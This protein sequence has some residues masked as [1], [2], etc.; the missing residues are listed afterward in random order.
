MTEWNPSATSEFVPPGFTVPTY[1]ADRYAPLADRIGGIL[2]TTGD[3]VFVQAEAIVAL[4]A[5]AASVGAPGRRVLVLVTSPYGDVFGRWL[6]AAGSDVRYLRAAGATAIHPDQLSIALEQTPA[7]VVSITHGEAATGVA[8]PLEQLAAVARAHGAL[9]V[10]DAV[11]SVGAHQLNVDAWGIDIAVIGPQK[12]LGGP[13]ALSAV[14]VSTAAWA[15]FDGPL[16]SVLSLIDLK[17]DWLDVGRGLLPGTPD[18]R[19]FWALENAVQTFLVEGTDAVIQRHAQASALARAAVSA[20]VSG[21]GIG[22]SPADDHDASHL[23]TLAPVPVGIDIDDLVARA[24]RL[25]DTVSLALGDAAGRF[26][27]LN[28]TGRRANFP[29]VAT[30]VNAYAIALHGLGVDVDLESLATVLNGSDRA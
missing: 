8:N 27:R 29:S 10:V 17:R 11:A 18:P 15:S 19:S 28:H 9:V 30:A 7:D 24:R 20:T 2:G 6:E 23:V 26:V 14:A 13:A 21:L 1:P 4:E 12:A 16:H 22:P 25:D 3:V 5:V